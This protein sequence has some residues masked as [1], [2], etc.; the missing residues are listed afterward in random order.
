MLV[1][2]EVSKVE[3]VRKKATESV[4]DFEVQSAVVGIRLEVGI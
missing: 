3:K 2:K 1:A 4:D